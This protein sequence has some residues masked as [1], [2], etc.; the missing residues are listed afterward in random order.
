MAGLER[1]SLVSLAL[2]LAEE[3]LRLQSVIGGL[4]KRKRAKVQVTFDPNILKRVQEAIN[5]PQII[6]NNQAINHNNLKVFYII[7]FVV[8]TLILAFNVSTRLDPQPRIEIVQTEW[9]SYRFVSFAKYLERDRIEL[10]RLNWAKWFVKKNRLDES[11]SV[12]VSRQLAPQP[13][14]ENVLTEWILFSFV[15]WTKYLKRD[16]IEL[17][18]LNWAKWF[19]KKNRL[20]ESQSSDVSRHHHLE[21]EPRIENDEARTPHQD[22]S[23]QV[24]VEF[25]TSMPSDVA[26]DFKQSHHVSYDISKGD[27]EARD[28]VKNSHP[29][30][31][32]FYEQMTEF[33]FVC[34]VML[35]SLRFVLA[36]LRLE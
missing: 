24:Q 33:V 25:T 9:I 10:N 19:V 5:E 11:Q 29:P 15:S 2:G 14:I 21:L 18:R 28:I 31:P 6:H 32:L 7:I 26:K 12:D 20:D 36:W 8:G 1:E 16:R 30:V 27:H 4:Q 35:L 34:V 3:N 13:K 17:N 23:K 22:W